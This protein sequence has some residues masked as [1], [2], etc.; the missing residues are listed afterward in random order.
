MKAKMHLLLAD[1]LL[2]AQVINE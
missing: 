1:V 2:V